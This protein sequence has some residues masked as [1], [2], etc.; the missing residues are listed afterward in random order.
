MKMKIEWYKECLKNSKKYNNDRIRQLL[1]HVYVI[2][3]N[4]EYDNFR[5][6]Q[7]DEAVRKKKDGFDSDRFLK[8]L[9]TDTRNKRIKSQLFEIEKIIK[10]EV[11]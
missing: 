9:N 5:Q 1:E 3:N 2:L 6:Y 10:Q 4:V 7:I 8:T 11:K